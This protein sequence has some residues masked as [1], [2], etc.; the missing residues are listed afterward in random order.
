MNISVRLSR[1]VNAHWAT[2]FL[3]L[4]RPVSGRATGRPG[5]S[6]FDLDESGFDALSLAHRVVAVEE[7]GEGIMDDAVVNGIGQSAFAD[8]AVPVSIP[9]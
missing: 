4:S 5:G 9:E 6:A 3:I 1:R 2:V 8:P 7:D